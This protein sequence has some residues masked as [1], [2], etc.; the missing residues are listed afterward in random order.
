ML[1]QQLCKGLVHAHERELKHRD[2]HLK[3][4]A[5]SLERELTHRDLH[6]K[7]LQLFLRHLWA[8][9]VIISIISIATIVS[10]MVMTF[11]LLKVKEEQK[12]R[13]EVQNSKYEG[14]LQEKNERIQHLEREEKSKANGNQHLLSPQQIPFIYSTHQFP[15][16]TS[17]T[18]G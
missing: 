3:Y 7:D 16:L 4:L 17:S 8:C 13:L 14:V 6:L 10:L 15:G 5:E 9:I 18:H 2:F 1:G 12:R 11:F